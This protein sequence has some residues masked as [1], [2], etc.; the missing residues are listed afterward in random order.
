M[1]RSAALVLASVWMAAGCSALGPMA[2]PP[3]DGPARVATPSLPPMVYG[4]YLDNDVGAINFAAWAFAT[5]SNTRG[6]PAEAA[7]AIIAVEYLAGELVDNPRWVEID[8]NTKFRLRQARDAVRQ[9]VGIRDDAPPQVVVDALLAFVA[10][11]GSGDVATAS[12]VL[13]AP[14]FS[15]GPQATFETL[16]NLPYVQQANLATSRV[17]AQ[18][19][20]S[21]GSAG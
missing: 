11:M 21:G 6:N 12:A 15:R 13:A 1:R 16:A 9:V 8:S 17:A 20:H 10:D 5:P 14:L 2:W 19:L 18:A 4:V 3:K 7:R